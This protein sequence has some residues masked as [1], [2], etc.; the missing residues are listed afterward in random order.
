MG[1]LAQMRN[2]VEVS[3]ARGL[4]GSNAHKHA[5]QFNDASGRAL[6][7]AGQSVGLQSARR[8][9]IHPMM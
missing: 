7:D 3:A 2:I 8:G 5:C 9:I 6:T 1:L 4:D